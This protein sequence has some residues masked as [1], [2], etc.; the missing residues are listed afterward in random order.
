MQSLEAFKPTRS[1]QQKQRPQLV[2]FGAN[3]K[4]GS[5]TGQ[6]KSADGN[7]TELSALNNKEASRITRHNA[8][9][10]HIGGSRVVISG[11]IERLTLKKVS[12]SVYF[13]RLI[14]IKFHRVFRLIG[15]HCRFAQWKD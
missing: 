2:V 3:T 5:M 4:V 6:I 15:E 11:G 8:S 9:Y 12:S 10:A 1:K 7:W 13:I 14:S